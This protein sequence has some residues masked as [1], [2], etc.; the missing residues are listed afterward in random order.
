MVDAAAINWRVV[1]VRFGQAIRNDAGN[2]ERSG[3]L[4]SAGRWKYRGASG[5]RA[6]DRAPGSAPCSTGAPA[7][8]ESGRAIP[9]DA[10]RLHPDCRDDAPAVRPSCLALTL[11]NRS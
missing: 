4:D 11:A 10:P 1:P 9:V 2:V 8:A 3:S 7:A 6:V 5:L